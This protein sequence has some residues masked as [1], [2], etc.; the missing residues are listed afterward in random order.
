MISSRFNNPS[1]NLEAPGILKRWPGIVL[2]LIVVVIAFSVFL[3]PVASGEESNYAAL[4]DWTESQRTAGQGT[5]EIQGA[6]YSILVPISNISSKDIIL[7]ISPEADRF[8]EGA[9]N[10]DYEDFLADGGKLKPVQEIARLLGAAGISR[11]DS[12]VITGQCLPCGGGPAPATYTYW[13]LKYLG[14]DKVR[15]LDGGIENWVAAGLPTSNES[16]VRQATN[17]APEIKAE[18]L[19]TRDFVLNSGAQIVDARSAQ[20]YALGSIPGAVNLPTEYVLDNE[21]IMDMPK[22]EEAFSGLE[23]DNSVVGRAC[24]PSAPPRWP[25]CT[26]TRWSTTWP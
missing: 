12:V 2:A 18:L 10:I 7:D 23:K 16:S 15:G 5:A 1:S 4:S 11:H 24:G 17:Y 13:L 19:A 9:I 26:S 14:H 25:A 21:S 3:H 8:I 6:N 20:E 22:L